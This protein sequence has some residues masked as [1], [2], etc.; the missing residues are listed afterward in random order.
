MNFIT[1]STNFLRPSRYLALTLLVYVLF[2][3]GTS[4]YTIAEPAVKPLQSKQVFKQQLSDQWGIELTALRMT[5][6]GHMI[7]FRYRVLDK[8][9]A[10]PLHKRET[11]P[12]L[13]HQA[14]GKVLAVPNTAKVGSLRNSY[15]PQE[16]R[17]YWMFFGNNGVIKNGDKVSV[18]IGDFRADGLIVE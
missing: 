14:S 3:Q 17:I 18:V 4:A 7:D 1:I 2:F 8:E 16:G 9:K 10:A 6:A 12:Y 15:L 11:K 13:V 5:A